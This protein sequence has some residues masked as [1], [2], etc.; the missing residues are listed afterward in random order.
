MPLKNTLKA[1]DCCQELR[2]VVSVQESS[3]LFSCCPPADG[4]MMISMVSE[5]ELQGGAAAWHL[6]SQAR[7][8]IFTEA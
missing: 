2:A 1:S 6:A 7:P 8:G 5:V 3:L 4:W